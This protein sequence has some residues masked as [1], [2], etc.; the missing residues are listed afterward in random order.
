MR[1]KLML[2]ADALSVASFVT[3][4]A[5]SANGTVRGQ[6]ADAWAAIVTRTNCLTTPCCP[7]SVTCLT[8]ASVCR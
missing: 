3:G 1:K 4:E 8:Q 5:G 7:A 2:D 6:A